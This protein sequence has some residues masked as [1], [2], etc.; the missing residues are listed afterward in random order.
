MLALPDRLAPQ[1]FDQPTVGDTRT[2]I[3]TAIREV[4]DDL[5]EPKIEIETDPEI[6][7][8]TDPEADGVKGPRGAEAAA[9]SDD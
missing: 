3:R 9:G 4:L 2:L 5:A 8:L 7:G 1:A 6:N